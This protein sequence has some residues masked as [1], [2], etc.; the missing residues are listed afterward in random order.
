MQMLLVSFVK[1]H[2]SPET[3]YFFECSYSSQIWEYLS[4]D[5]LRSSYSNDWS[6]IVSLLCDGDRE[7]KRSFCLRYVFQ[8]AIYA[9]WRERNKI[10]HG[11][12]VMLIS[13]LKKTIYKGIRN[14]LSLIKKD[15][16]KGM[17]G[18]LQFWFETRG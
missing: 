10:K 4:L 13:I 16:R 1:W 7:R 12:K 8:A 15:R 6:I 17:E 14:K 5:I 9:I 3:I 18:V 11:E 2:W